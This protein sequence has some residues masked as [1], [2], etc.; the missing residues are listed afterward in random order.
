MKTARVSAGALPALVF[1]V[2]SFMGTRIPAA[3][4]MPVGA[5]GAV[6]SCRIDPSTAS[7]PIGTQHNFTVLVTV[8]D[9]P[10]PEVEVAYTVMTGP[11]DWLLELGVT[12]PS[13][14]LTVSYADT[15]GSGTDDIRV[16]GLIDEE[17]FECAA[18]AI[19]ENAPTEGIGD[20]NDDGKVT[21]DELIRG[22][23]IALG[24]LPLAGCPGLDL[25]T[26]GAVAVD[27][28]VRAV[29]DALR[30]GAGPVPPDEV[31]TE[32]PLDPGQPVHV[33]LSDGTAVDLPAV[34]DPGGPSAGPFS[35]VQV[36]RAASDVDLSASE[37]NPVGTMRV[38][39]FAPFDS[40]A[41]ANNGNG[42]IGR[43]QATEF[44]PTLTLPRSTLGTADPDAVTAVA[45]VGDLYVAGRL[46][47]DAVR[48]LPVSYDELGNL[49]VRDIYFPR[50]ILSD[51]EERAAAAVSLRAPALRSRRV[52][53]V[54]ASLLTSVNWSKDP[55]LV[56][57]VP[58]SSSPANRVPLD[59]LA[60]TDPGKAATEARRCVNNIVILVHGHNEQE[61]NGFLPPS[62]ETPW[63]Y[64]YKRDVWTLFYD[65][66]LKNDPKARLACTAFYEFIYPTYRPVVTPY[67]GMTRLDEGFAEALAKEL[68]PF[69]DSGAD[70]RLY[71]VAHSMG[72]IVSRAGVQIMDPKLDKWLRKLVTWGSP[73]LGSPLPSLAF[74]LMA[75]PP[76]RIHT[77]PGWT[78]L[79]LDV[80]GSDAL[81]E[82][83]VEGVSQAQLPAPGPREYRWAR[84]ST[85]TPR[86]INLDNV[87]DLTDD[88]K[89]TAPLWR[90]FNF[91]DGTW[92]YNENLR[93]LNTNDRHVQDGKY[94]TIFGV[95][96]KR[97]TWKK[98]VFGYISY[99]DPYSTTQTGVGAFAIEL[100]MDAAPLV[101]GENYNSSDGAVPVASMVASG[102]VG[103]LDIY[104]LG[105][106]DHEEYYGAPD[107]SGTFTEPAKA[108]YTDQTTLSVLK[109]LSD[110]VAC[111]S[112][113]FTREPPFS[114]RPAD[115]VEIAGALAWPG[116]DKPGLRIASLKV[117]AD[118]N[119]GRLAVLSVQPDGTFSGA[120]PASGLPTTGSFTLT[121]VAAFK[122]NTELRK[123]WLRGLTLPV[124]NGF[125]LG[126]TPTTEGDQGS[127]IHIDG[128]GFGAKMLPSSS[129]AFGGTKAE[130]LLVDG[131]PYWDDWSI[132]VKVPFVGKG[133]VPVTVTAGGITSAPRNFTVTDIFADT[134]LSATAAYAKCLTDVVD[135]PITWSGFSF[136]GRKRTE[137]SNAAVTGWSELTLRGT[138]DRTTQTLTRLEASDHSQRQFS[139]GSSSLEEIDFAFQTVWVGQ[140]GMEVRGP[141]S[142]DVLSSYRFYRKNTDSTTITKTKEDLQATPGLPPLMHIALFFH[143]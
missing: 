101:M 55:K 123:D 132:K 115:T 54:P 65:H 137:F 10:Q 8:G 79:G 15:G 19:W 42:G 119:V 26:D 52:R 44:I 59:A 35:T 77:P 134:L 58:S 104:N 83:L 103:L 51:L 100:L 102:V 68:K 73:H 32:A 95:T 105:D 49:Q 99:P 18:T 89:A 12:G 61:K 45:R 126:F 3:E 74:A 6:A 78:A 53:Y 17:Y 86:E 84:S 117:E 27:E 111:P 37:L 109:V 87:L 39:T 75:T 118:R 69:L 141:R 25:D 22:V 57:M 93:S 133:V 142:F 131:R 138:I 139:D 108:T 71:V 33:E 129:V 36:S 130:V 97:P 28:L 122:D 41:F 94:A 20:C 113:T 62:I 13:G 24:R 46:E 67:G 1:A 110:D 31:S 34:T 56:R 38:L 120:F 98:S 143:N 136:E 4:T 64:P 116:D 47:P 127:I 88:Q 80:S 2:V 72:G 48:F 63:E 125:Y 124:I 114:I 14:T 23:H 96:T 85:S 92:L 66:V 112:F 50:S 82:L 106:I 107:A 121:L 5:N 30:E 90:R 60:L 128:S 135:V 16:W 76:Y 7:H 70:Y 91:T 140:T 21:I 81:T 29:I 43:L 40:N 11:N 9:A